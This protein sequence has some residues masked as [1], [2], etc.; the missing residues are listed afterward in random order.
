MKCYK[1]QGEGHMAR[2][3]PSNEDGGQ[4]QGAPY[5]RQKQDEN[6][7]G[8]AGWDNNGGGDA[9]GLKTDGWGTNDQAPA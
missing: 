3:C 9:G 1:C 6:P 4:D 8:G 5:K 2:A 7:S